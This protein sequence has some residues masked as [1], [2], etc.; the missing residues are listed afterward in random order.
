V[1][2]GVAGLAVTVSLFD[3]TAQPVS[4]P[5]NALDNATVKTVKQG[6]EKESTPSATQSAPM[7]EWPY[8][9]CHHSKD[10]DA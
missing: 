3:G 5:A 4:K 9:G 10:S 8:E 2:V 7:S 1:F 6:T